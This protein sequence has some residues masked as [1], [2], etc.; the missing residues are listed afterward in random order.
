MFK[1]YK[2]YIIRI[3]VPSS[4]LGGHLSTLQLISLYKIVNTDLD[5]QWGN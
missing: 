5:W 2:V 4:A 1:V 3:F